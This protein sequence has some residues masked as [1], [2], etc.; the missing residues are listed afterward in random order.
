MVEEIEEA[1]V[2][3]EV[4]TIHLETTKAESSKVE[5]HPK[6]QNPPMVQELSRVAFAPA[7]TPK[8]GRRMANVLDAVLRPSK[9]TTPAPTKIFKDK[10][11]ELG[12]T[13]DKSASLDLGKAGPSEL[14]PLD[15]NFESLP[16]KISLPIPKLSC[17]EDLGYIIHHASRKKLSKEQTAEVQYH[18]KDLKY[19]QGSL[20]YGRNDEDDYLYYLP[21]NKEIDVCQEMLDNMGYP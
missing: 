9:I 11:D 20:V 5:Q 8:K 15:Q 18:A 10:A 3:A 2:V 14:Q 4:P 16:E 17:L 6:L 21:D 19:P 13:I 12:K 7:G 1:V